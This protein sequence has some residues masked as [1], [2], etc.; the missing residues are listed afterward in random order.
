MTMPT[1]ATELLAALAASPDAPEPTPPPPA[2]WPDLD[3]PARDPNQ[4]LAEWL[5]ADAPPADAMTEARRRIAD[6][7]Q[8]VR[9]AS[10]ARV[11]A[12]V[13]NELLLRRLLASPTDA[14]RLA[15]RG[16]IPTCDA[17]GPMR[18]TDSRGPRARIGG[19]WQA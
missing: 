7:A 18:S 16:P 5:L 4:A 2:S 14:E 17:Y 8:A 19:G 13:R 1:T 12:L 9:A 6:A 10:E 3:A 11:R 15:A